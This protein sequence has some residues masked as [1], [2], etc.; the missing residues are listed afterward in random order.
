MW[1]LYYSMP[2]VSSCCIQPIMFFELSVK[3]LGEL[4]VSLELNNPPYYLMLYIQEPHVIRSPSNCKMKIMHLRLPLLKKCLICIQKAY[5]MYA[6]HL[7]VSY[8]FYMRTQ[9]CHHFTML[10][11]AGARINPNRVYFRNSTRGEETT[12]LWRETQRD[13]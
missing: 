10:Y 6:W 4:C 7:H 9:C 13:S 5:C 8:K 1:P 3:V 2:V 12:F 11:V